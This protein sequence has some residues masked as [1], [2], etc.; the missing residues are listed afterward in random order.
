MNGKQLLKPGQIAK[1]TGLHPSKVSR[2]RTK[3]K[4]LAQEVLETI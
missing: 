3:L 4:G 2:I 1:Q